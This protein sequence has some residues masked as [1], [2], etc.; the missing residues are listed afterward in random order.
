MTT[1]EYLRERDRIM[2]LLIERQ[3]TLRLSSWQVAQK[4]IGADIIELAN[5]QRIFGAY[6]NLGRWKRGVVNPSLQSIML[7]AHALGLKMR[8]DPDDG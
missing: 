5:V 8:F 4:M 1:A 7:W 6:K 3:E 2:G